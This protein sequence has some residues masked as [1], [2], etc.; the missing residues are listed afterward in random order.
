MGVLIGIVGKPSSGKTT[1]LNA[2]CGTSAKTG[3]YPFTTIDPNQGVGFVT[4]PCVC[5]EL[6]V[7]C[8]PRNSECID[9]IRKIPIKLI[10]V[11]GLVP[12]AYKG[13]GMGNQF[14]ADLA[15]ADILIHVVDA[16]GSL[17][18]EG[19]NVE[20][21][22]HDPMIDISFLED[23]ITQW[24]NGIL[25]K[26][27][28]RAIRKAQT[29]Q[30]NIID[31]ITEK[32]TGLK[33]T[34][35]DIL[36]AVNESN[37]DLKNVQNWTDEEILKLCN[38]VQKIGKPILI[39][40]NKI[41]KPTSKSHLENLQN[42]FGNFVIPTTALTD[43]VLKN[44]NTQRKINYISES[45][46]LEIIDELS[47]KEQQIIL[48]IEKEIL[49]PYKTT[50]VFETLNRAVFDVLKLIPVYPVADSTHYSDQDGRI[51]PEVFLV[52]EGTT[53]KELA[54]IIHQDL[55]KNF[56]YGVDAK[57]NRKLSDKSVIKFGDVI[58]IVAAV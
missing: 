11:A 52:K 45:G 50:G 57:T 9:R 7:T 32:F 24:M 37:L 6:N 2:L 12:G 54:G 55:F 43:L 36:H 56:I 23:E 33:I 20:P 17:N 31:F 49:L 29:E 44:L 26:D 40:A 38:S 13:R 27:W 22:S 41:D 1:F 16:S 14:L 18:E 8:Q 42:M 5:N 51:L 53:V 46:K 3:D 25:K 4:T 28:N 19:E 39:A 34:K 58:R 15:Q 10:D 48:K 47:T 30:K 21:G 35:S